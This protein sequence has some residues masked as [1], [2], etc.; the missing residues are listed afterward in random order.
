MKPKIY[1]VGIGPGD[2]N[3]LIP[4][5]REIVQKAHVILGYKEYFRYIT[6]FVTED[7]ICVKSGMRKERERA[8]Q[9]FEYAKQG[10]TVAVISSGD[11]QIYGMAPLIYE[12][13]DQEYQDIEIES[14]PGITSM[15]SAAAKLGAPLGHD[16]CVISLSDLLTSWQ[17]IEER[18]VAAARA[19]FV[20][21]VYNPKSKERFWQLHRFKEIFLSYR[22]D[23]TPVAVCRHINRAEEQIEITK[24]SS[25][26]MEK[27]DMSTI[28][29][30]GN[31]QSYA[32]RDRIITPRGYYAQPPEEE[33][34]GKQIMSES[35]RTIMN[36][37]QH[38]DIPYDR[39]WAIMHCIHTTADFEFEHLLHFSDGVLEQLY[40]ELTGGLRVITDV[41]M[42]K[43]GIRQSA[44]ARYG[45]EVQSCLEDKRV[46]QLAQ[47]QHITRTQAGI[48]L[49]VQEHPNALF[50]IGNAPTA[51]MELCKQIRDHNYRPK[52]VIAAPVGFVNVK[53]SK[54]HLKALPDVPKIIVE[55]RKGGS[56]VAATLVNAIVSLDDAE[57]QIVGNDV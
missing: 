46:A 7:K 50:V 23:Q 44:C 15:L 21:A 13:A 9:A 12:M 17:V 51:L 47:E 14:I 16:F 28:L 5:A 26:D 3:L 37:M 31:S 41:T 19:D 36:E 27:V 32:S 11:S 48:R 18:I 24:L 20:T 57:K 54:Y 39:K 2:Q 4:L 56:P 33:K 52:G 10:Y 34:P 53:E 8:A 1:I 29:I 38:P 45:I 35:F 43:A 55:G 30:I 49:A 22:L 42:V 25:M 6:P 40:Q